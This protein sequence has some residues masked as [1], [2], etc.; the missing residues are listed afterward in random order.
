[1]LP[2][3]PKEHH[4]I[5]RQ[6]GPALVAGMAEAAVPAR[7]QSIMSPAVVQGISR[8]AGL[9]STNGVPARA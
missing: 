7:F 4:A 6:D 5:D 8:G 9:E 2:D 1:M 3:H